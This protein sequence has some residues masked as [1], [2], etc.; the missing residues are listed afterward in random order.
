M[1]ELILV[2]L[3][4]SIISAVA[5]PNFSKGK[6]RTAQKGPRANLKLIGAAQKV[7]RLEHGVYG[8]CT[9]NATTGDCSAILKLALSGGGW[10]YSS[11]GQ[12]SATITA[13]KGACT[14]TLTSANFDAEPVASGTCN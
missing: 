11:S 8:Q 6:L 3:I 2:I 4:I 10:D 14:Y 13:T 7:Y 5:L 1:I 12:A 9:P